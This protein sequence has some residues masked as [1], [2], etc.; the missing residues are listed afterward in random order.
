MALWDRV[1]D[2]FG[3]DRHDDRNRDRDRDSDRDRDRD[4]GY[5]S[6]WGSG[7][8]R[9]QNE[10]H[11]DYGRADHG[12]RESSRYDGREAY[13]R[14]RIRGGDDYRNDYDPDR[15]GGYRGW[16]DREECENRWRDDDWY[17]GP[18]RW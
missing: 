1:R 10:P 7:D 13:E 3:W 12:Y 18:N 15:P 5:G 17:R 6:R 14:G 2:G 16:N 4:R 11:R 8:Y 9:R